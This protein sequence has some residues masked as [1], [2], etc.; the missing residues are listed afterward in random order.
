MSFDR[1]N[2]YSILFEIVNP[3][4]FLRLYDLFAQKGMVSSKP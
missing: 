3:V 1:G 4:C 2:Q